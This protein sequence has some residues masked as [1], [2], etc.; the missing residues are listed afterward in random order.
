MVK[1][2]LEISEPVHR[3]VFQLPETNS[4]EVAQQR[5]L[6]RSRHSDNS[7]A[8]AIR[9]PDKGLRAHA[10]AC[11][12]LTPCE[13]IPKQNPRVHTNLSSRSY[14]LTCSHRP[15]FR[16]HYR[17]HIYPFWSPW[18]F[19]VVNTPESAAP[20]TEPSSGEEA[21]PVPSVDSRTSILPTHTAPPVQPRA[22]LHCGLAYLL[23]KGSM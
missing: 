20:P 6:T 12:A 3:R 15:S 2:K 14:V 23:K 1:R 8:G 13:T 7:R 18:R 22:P 17:E 10:P 11:L 21:E 16:R 4:G 19:S 9:E 5:P